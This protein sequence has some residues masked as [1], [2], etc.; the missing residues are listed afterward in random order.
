MKKYL[1]A[2]YHTHTVYCKHAW[3]TMREYIEA[4]IENGIQILG[5]SD[6]VPFPEDGEYVSDIRMSM[7]EAASYV[8]DIRA[9][10]D[11]YKDRIK[12]YI[13]FEAEYVKDYFGGN[14]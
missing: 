10:Q 14:K 13:G 11:E 7:E 12:I 8:E 5:F 3:G 9:L 4:A 2:N 1:K 6:H